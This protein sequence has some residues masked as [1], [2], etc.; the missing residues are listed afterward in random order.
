M[1]MRNKISIQYSSNANQFCDQLNLSLENTLAKWG[2][3]GAFNDRW[4]QLAAAGFYKY[5]KKLP[6]E[7]NYR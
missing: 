7:P 3:R 5:F 2:I 1:R 4:E 6:R